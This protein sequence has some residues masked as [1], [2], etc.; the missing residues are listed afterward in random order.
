[1][2]KHLSKTSPTPPASPGIPAQPKAPTGPS[3]P[4][5]GALPQLPST[6]GSPQSP[7]SAQ[8][9]QAPSGPP[10]NIASPT[11]PTKPAAPAQPAGK[12]FHFGGYRRKRTRRRKAR[13]KRRRK[14]TRRGGVKWKLR[15]P[16]KKKNKKPREHEEPLLAASQQVAARKTAPAR[17]VAQQSVEEKDPAEEM[18]NYRRILRAAAAAQLKYESARD[19]N[20]VNAYELQRLKNEAERKRWD[21]IRADNTTYTE[22]IQKMWDVNHSGR[23]LSDLTNQQRK[24]LQLLRAYDPAGWQAIKQ[25]TRPQGGGRRRKRSRR[26]RRR[27]RKP[28]ST[29]R[30]RRKKWL[31]KKLLGTWGE[32]TKKRRSPWTSEGTSCNPYLPLQCAGGLTCV[33][34]G[35]GIG[36]IKLG[37]RC[38][39]KN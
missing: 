9:P 32:K 30:R 5:K 7:Q 10:K 35:W 27:R 4:Q 8:A 6:P 14:K 28:R 11:S 3:A 17:G 25:P 2:G 33:P 26:T 15:N 12:G 18:A 1:M 38:V 16:F 24:D 21:F 31:K 39:M 23:R 22:F 36:P 19:G 29:R 20:T 13:T 34:S 37:G